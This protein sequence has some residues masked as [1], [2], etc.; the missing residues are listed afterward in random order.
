MKRIGAHVS[1][2][3]GVAQTP[4]TAHAIGATAFALFVK[5]QRQWQAPPLSS[6]Q[7]AQFRDAMQQYNYRPQDILPHDSY[8]INLGHPE[9]DLRRKSL[10]ALI[11]EMERCRS[12]GLSMINTHPGSHLNKTDPSHCLQLIADSINQAVAAVD[13]VIIVLENCAG[14]GTNVGYRFEQLAEIFSQVKDPSRVGFCLDTCHAFAAG[15][16]LTTEQGYDQTMAEFD[17]LIGLQHIRG[18]HLNDSKAA[19][20]SRV[21]R[22]HNLGQGHIGLTPFRCMMS[23]SR[24]NERPLIL[25][26]V[27][28]N[29]WPEEIRL[30]LSFCPD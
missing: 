3:G 2:A 30:L 10:Q 21:D 15:Y 14:Q 23:D 29:L 20:G 6:D 19:F 11:D 4:A 8:L 22:H 9:E 28:H 13:D 27:D 25:E 26:T 17:R 1:A 16:D 24:F 12:L 18:V 5:N 7:I